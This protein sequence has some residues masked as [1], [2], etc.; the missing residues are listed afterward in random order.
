VI[1]GEQK[2]VSKSFDSLRRF[3]ELIECH[4]PPVVCLERS[5]VVARG[6][7]ATVFSVWEESSSKVRFTQRQPIVGSTAVAYGL[8]ERANLVGCCRM[9]MSEI[10]SRRYRITQ[11]PNNEERC[12]QNLDRNT[13]LQQPLEHLHG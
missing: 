13:C 5:C 2:C 10:R 3:A 9:E 7:F 11:P 12:A 8:F 6:L 1:V 4:A